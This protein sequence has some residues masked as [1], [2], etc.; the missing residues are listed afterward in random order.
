M[1]TAARHLPA[2]EAETLWLLAD[3]LTRRGRIA[4]APLNTAEVM[5]PADGG[6]PVHRHPS[7]ETFTVLS[8]VVIFTLETAAGLAEVMAGPGDLIAIPGGSWHGYRNGNGA[9]ATMLIVYDD[10]L[11]AFFSEAGQREAAAVT[12]E[13][14]G[15]VIACAVRH[16]ME[17]KA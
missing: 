4:G 3:R 6:V 9:P 5:V 7:P 15:A 14:A 2:G 11:E 10:T 13:R 12:P 16:G 8:G 17:I 1:T